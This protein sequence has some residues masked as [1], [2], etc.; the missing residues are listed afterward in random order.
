MA[1]GGGGGAAAKGRGVGCMEAKPICTIRDWRRMTRPD[2]GE[3]VA[4]GG[5]ASSTNGGDE[6]RTVQGAD[7]IRARSHPWMVHISALHAPYS[8]KRL[9]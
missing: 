4:I 6:G 8:A 5:A 3:V 2:T 7:N 9:A 1:R